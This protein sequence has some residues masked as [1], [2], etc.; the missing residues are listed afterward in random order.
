MSMAMMSLRGMILQLL[1]L[2]LHN[3]GPRNLAIQ[4]YRVLSVEDNK[5]IDEY[6]R[7]QL[8]KVIIVQQDKASSTQFT[9]VLREAWY[10]TQCTP[11]SYVHVF[12]RFDSNKRCIINNAENILV[13]HPDHLVS[14]TV[15]ADSFGCVRRA[16]LQDRVKATGAAS[17]PMLFGNLL[18]EIFQ[19]ALKR[20]RWDINTTT[21]ILQDIVPRHFETLA[22]LNMNMNQ[23][24]EQLIPKMLEM[25][26]WAAIFVQKNP[27]RDAVVESRG[28]RKNIMSINKLLD[29]EEHV[30]SPNYGLKGN[31]DATVQVTMD[32]DGQRKT[33]TVPLEL[34]TGKRVNEAHQAQTALYTL[35]ISDRYDLDV[36]DGVL[37]YLEGSKT[38]RVKAIRHELIHMIMKRN[39]LAGYIRERITLPPMLQPG[40]QRLCNGCYAQTSCYLYHTLS[41]DGDGSLIDKKEPFEK[42]VSDLKPSHSKFFKNWDSL[43]TKEESEMMKFRRELWTMLSLER[44]KVN[45]CFTNVVIVPDTTVDDKQSNSKINRY[46]YAF[47]KKTF[48]AGFSFRESQITTGEPIVVSDEQGHFALANGYVTNV[49]KHRIH[50]AVDRRLHNARRRKSG[51][52]SQNN[53]T[54]SGIMEVEPQ[55]STLKENP[56][57]EPIL[58]RIDK[59]EFSNGMAAVRNNILQI[60]DDSVFKA[61]DL[62]WRAG[63]TCHC[64]V[65]SP[66]SILKQ[67]STWS[68]SIVCAQTSC[69]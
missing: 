28:G 35:L 20:N 33:L 22:E 14:A 47:E 50:I 5:Y 60:M 43:I 7:D 57:E 16:V 37:Y 52:C 18:H 40:Q 24:K 2:E 6:Q 53:Q 39:E 3:I 48:K 44:E 25:E 32:E 13:I 38:L 34:K 58:Y 41:E 1:K 66:N 29:V 63:L 56:L 42:L 10:N 31:I 36:T 67:W 27:A 49:S 69:L 23:L 21:S 55:S 19:E 12:G 46:Q 17:P 62:H 45:R 51:F 8:E 64:S 15:V 11:D 68:T 30:W 54:F 26:A 65:F 61:R 9:V 4:R 59:D